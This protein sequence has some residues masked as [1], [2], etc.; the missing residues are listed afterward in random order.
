MSTSCYAPI[1]SCRQFIISPFSY[2]LE[3]T[4]SCGARESDQAQTNKI[5]MYFAVVPLCTPGLGL[6]FSLN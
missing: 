6:I 1:P 5:L 2:L 3:N 4:D